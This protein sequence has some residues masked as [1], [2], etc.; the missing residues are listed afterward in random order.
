MTAWIC[1]T[2]GVQYPPS[3]EPPGRCPICEDPRQYV[4]LEGQKWT[5]LDDM[6]ATHSNHL[7]DREPGVTSIQTQPGFAIRQ[8]AYLIETPEGNLLWDCLTLLDAQTID[9]IRK[10]GGVRAIAISHPHYYGT[11]IEWSQ[12]FDDAPIWIHEDDRAWVM[13]PGPQVQFWRGETNQLFGSIRL[14]RCGGHFD[15]FQVA[16]WP[17][18]AEGRGVLFAGDQPQVC[19]DTKWVTFMYS[20]PNW[21]PLDAKPVRRVV[22]SLEP[23]KFDRLYGAFGRNL[24]TGAKQIIQRSEERYLRA[25]GA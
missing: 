24:M 13:R 25:I 21:I 10:H 8:H 2:C 18:G 9:A 12:A 23:W 3:E 20:Y 22:A 17:D 7:I 19:M 4:G 1:S 5:T 14:I 6:R 16:H 11:M 15:G